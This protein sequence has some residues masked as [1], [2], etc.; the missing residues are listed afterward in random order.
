M[1][2]WLKPVLMAFVVVVLVIL[3]VTI[4]VAAVLPVLNAISSAR[5]MYARAPEDGQLNVLATVL[6]GIVAAV[7]AFVGALVGALIGAHDAKNANRLTE[8]ALNLRTQVVFLVEPNRDDLARFRVLNAGA[9]ITIRHVQMAFPA[10]KTAEEYRI[11]VSIVSPD[12]LSGGVR[13]ASADAQTFE[14]DR[15]AVMQ[16]INVLSK[17]GF[18]SYYL[19]VTDDMGHVGSFVGE[20]IRLKPGRHV[21]YHVSATSMIAQV[22]PGTSSERVCPEATGCVVSVPTGV[23]R[24]RCWPATCDD[25]CCIDN[26][27]TGNDDQCLANGTSAP[28]SSPNRRYRTHPFVCGIG[29]AECTECGHGPHGGC[30]SA[31]G[32]CEHGNTDDTCGKNGVICADCRTTGQVCEDGLCTSP[33]KTTSAPVASS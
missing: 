22:C 26:K 24:C 33:K 25:G 14:M 5:E 9:P 32:H 19:R 21:S 3:G 10:P 4:L 7:I 18:A 12:P 30:C 16:A 20:Q 11:T 2:R 29:G 13:I 28:V 1:L 17:E 8:R 6:I 15:G 27:L 31:N 23:G